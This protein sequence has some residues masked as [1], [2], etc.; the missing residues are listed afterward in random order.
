MIAALA[1]VS[2]V[3]VAAL[4]TT[5]IERRSEARH[6]FLRVAEVTDTTIDP[7]VWGQ[8]FPLQYDTYIRTVD[9]VR[10]R[11]GGS[12]AMPR[13]PTDADPRSVVAQSRLEDDTRLREFWAGY[14]FAEDFREER[15]HAYMLSD[16]IYTRRQLVA[17]QPGACLNCHASVYVAYMRAGDGDLVQGFHR[18]NAMPF[19]EA[20]QLVN[21]PISCIDCHDPGNMQ[22]RI[23]R[24]AF[25]EGMRVWMASRGVQ[26][27]DVN[28]QATRHEMRTFVCAQCHVE[29]YFR[30]PERTLTFPWAK[31]LL[32]DSILAYFDSTGHRDWVH[33]RSGAPVLKAQH[34]EFEMYMQGTH[35]RAGVACAD[36][37][38]P[39]ERV[40]AMKISSHHVRSPIL[41]IDRS[42]QPCHRA[43]EE[44]LRQ[45]VYNIQ[46]RTYEIR[47]LA[48]DAVLQLVRDIEAV[49]QRDS[50]DPRLPQARRFHHMAQFLADFVEAENSMGFHAPQEAVRVGARAIDYARL[51][52]VALQS[53]LL[54][55]DPVGAAR[56]P[57]GAS[58]REPAVPEGGGPATPAGR[59]PR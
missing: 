34:P 33:A 26:N 36:C 7:R 21:H 48:I 18:V 11:Y 19:Q 43:S 32:A 46:D 16:Q 22:L 44:E 4:L 41:S 8:N 47:N 51:G 20:V 14:P 3:A 52:Q 25:M 5:I 39:Y 17:Q 23:T 45:R 38:M 58:L 1:A 24:P 37:H 29:Y 30:G 28:R 54:P 15:G 35:A 9:Q 40:G 53:G 56:G 10:T 42:C 55:A 57:A 2:A 13:T 6:P 49:A 59:P 50:N 27:Y 12:E 31:G